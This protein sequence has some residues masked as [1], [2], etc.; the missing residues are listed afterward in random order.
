LQN[1]VN[2]FNGLAQNPIGY[3][4]T[5]PKNLSMINKLLKFS[6]IFL[7]RIADFAKREPFYSFSPR[8]WQAGDDAALPTGTVRTGL[9]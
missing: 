6:A 7:G 2:D 4:Y 9:I 3:R 1:W 5:I 8:P